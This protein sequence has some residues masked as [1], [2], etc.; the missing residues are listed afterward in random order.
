MIAHTN[1]I[2][3]QRAAMAGK[4]VA[5]KIAVQVQCPMCTHSVPAE[6]AYGGRRATV[7]RGQKCTR[8]KSSLDASS[9]LF[10]RAAA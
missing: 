6:A 10:E 9:V 1:E 5:K 8:C 3:M 4:I 2:Q 7:L